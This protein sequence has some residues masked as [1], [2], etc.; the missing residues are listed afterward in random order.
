MEL[1]EDQ[2]V[3]KKGKEFTHCMRNTL[4]PYEDEME[5]CFIWIQHTLAEK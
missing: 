1:N 2:I 5:F 4:L 3:Q